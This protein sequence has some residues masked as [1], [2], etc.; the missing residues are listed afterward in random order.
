M[1]PASP[2]GLAAITPTKM[3]PACAIDEY[4]SMRLMSLWLMAIIDPT[5]IVKIAMI[6]IIGTQSQRIP[7]NA[8]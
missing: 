8:T 1:A 3:K 7:P 6:H 5:N 4:A 2:A